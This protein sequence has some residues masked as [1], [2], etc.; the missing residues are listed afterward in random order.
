MVRLEASHEARDRLRL[1]RTWAQLFYLFREFLD[2]FGEPRAFG[3]G[4]PFQP[5]PFV[6]DPKI[7]QH[8]S[9]GF[10]SFFRFN[11]TIL[12][13]AVSDVSAAHQNT[14]GTFC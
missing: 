11:I 2:H 5:E 13:M 10:S 1:I 9:D 8:Q 6:F 3:R 4:Y 14:V 12:V 7:V